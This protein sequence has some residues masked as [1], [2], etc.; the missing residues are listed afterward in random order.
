MLIYSPRAVYPAHCAA[1]NH[2]SV[3][4]R[5]A[6]NFLFSFFHVTPTVSNSL[7][8]AGCTHLVGLGNYSQ[9]YMLFLCLGINRLPRKWQTLSLPEFSHYSTKSAAALVFLRPKSVRHQNLIHLASTVHF[10][11][12]NSYL[13]IKYSSFKLHTNLRRF[14][15]KTKFPWCQGLH[16]HVFMDII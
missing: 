8:R 2:C 1:L 6:H 5:C 13:H 3:L 7:S 9:D 15:F 14:T 16:C 4:P 11:R 12:K 10:V